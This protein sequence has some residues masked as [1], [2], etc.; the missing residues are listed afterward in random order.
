MY[1]VVE[2]QRHYETI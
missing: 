1:A 2:L